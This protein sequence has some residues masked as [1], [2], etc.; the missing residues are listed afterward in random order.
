MGGGVSK[1]QSFFVQLVFYGK[2]DEQARVVGFDSMSKFH[3][4]KSGTYQNI[5]ESLYGIEKVR[6]EV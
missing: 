2:S 4:H 3:S 6:H 1:I 5:A